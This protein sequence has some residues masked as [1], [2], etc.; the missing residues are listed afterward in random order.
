MLLTSVRIFFL[1]FS[2]IKEGKNACLCR[3]QQAGKS[4]WLLSNIQIQKKN[5]PSEIDAKGILQYF[6]QAWKKKK[7][8][9][10]SPHTQTEHA[11]HSENRGM[12]GVGV[13]QTDGMRFNVLGVGFTLKSSRIVYLSG[14][15]MLARDD[16]QRE[17]YIATGTR[18]FKKRMTRSSTGTLSDL[19][20]H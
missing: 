9:P 10:L 19:P 2:S 1:G 3:C 11:S 5:K 15:D 6:N 8:L 7:S 14:S 4:F 12:S 18:Q 17:V 13:C 16:G 20:H